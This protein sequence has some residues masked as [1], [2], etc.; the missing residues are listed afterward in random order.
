MTKGNFF[1]LE[2]G[3]LCCCC[4]ILL[5]VRFN[6]KSV[7][8]CLLLVVLIMTWQLACCDNLPQLS[9]RFLTL[10]SFFVSCCCCCWCLF[11]LFYSLLFD[12]TFHQLRLWPVRC[13]INCSNRIF[14][15][16]CVIRT[17]NVNA[18]VRRGGLGSRNIRLFFS[19]SKTKW[20]KIKKIF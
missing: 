8:C 5:V 2:L 12:S 11:G 9:G 15:P 18:F 1:G 6:E 10:G 3:G 19:P 17:E 16:I 14:S 7:P 13:A 4:R 20:K